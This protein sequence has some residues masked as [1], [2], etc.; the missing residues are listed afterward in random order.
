[1]T[2][3]EFI[4]R[5]KW[6]ADKKESWRILKDATADGGSLQRWFEGDCD[7]FACT[8]LWLECGQSMSKFWWKLITLGAVFWLAKKPGGRY[9]VMLW[10]KGK[11]WIDNTQPVWSSE[12]TK[13]YRR[14]LPYPVILVKIKMMM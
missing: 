7:D 8:V 11:G 14:I 2:T 1:M 9:H 3:E 10:M 5:F 6:T 12:S 4:R 13:S